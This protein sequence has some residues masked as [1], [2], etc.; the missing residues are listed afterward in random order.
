MTGLF[1][2]KKINDPAGVEKQQICIAL[3]ISQM[4]ASLFQNHKKVNQI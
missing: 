4:D 3:Q 1:Q 2:I